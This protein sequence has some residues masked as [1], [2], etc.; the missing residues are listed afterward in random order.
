M[1]IKPEIKRMVEFRQANLIESEDFFPFRES[2]S[3]VLCR[4]VLIYFNRDSKMKALTN[5]SYILKD[6]GL[7]VLSATEFLGKEYQD[8]FEPFR[9]GRFL[10]FRKRREDSG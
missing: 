6:G 7:L 5:I 4:N 8:L 9:A 1:L 2:F 10:F 3:V